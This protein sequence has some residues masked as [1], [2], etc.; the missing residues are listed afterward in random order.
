MPHLAE[1]SAQGACDRDSGECVCTDL[2]EGAACER[3]RCPADPSSNA[4]SH[5][6]SGHGQCLTMDKLAS[7]AKLLTTCD[8]EYCHHGDA[9]QYT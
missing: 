3:L 5:A 2:F 7:E 9:T 6:C 4:L 8:D 1:C